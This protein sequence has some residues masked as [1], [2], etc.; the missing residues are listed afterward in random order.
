MEGSLEAANPWRCLT[1]FLAANTVQHVQN[2]LD[3]QNDKIVVQLQDGVW[4]SFYLP[5][6]LVY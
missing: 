3:S 4:H 6:N 5:T 2:T 1:Q